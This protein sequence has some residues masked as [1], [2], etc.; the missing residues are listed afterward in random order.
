MK[1]TIF[2]SFIVT[3]ALLDL[4][5]LVGTLIFAAG[6]VMAAYIWVRWGTDGNDKSCQEERV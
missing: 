5:T 2:S 1:K 6:M 4:S 3:W